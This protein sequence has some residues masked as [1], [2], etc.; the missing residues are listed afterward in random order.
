MNIF[1]DLFRQPTQKVKGAPAPDR[2]RELFPGVVERNP[3]LHLWSP[4][5]VAPEQGQRL[6]IGVATWSV[7]DMNT[8]DLVAQLPDNGVRVDVFDVDAFSADEL[9]G[10]FP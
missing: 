10:F 2:R 7:Y 8:L 5:Q 9:A 1:H 6:V 3:K 4:D